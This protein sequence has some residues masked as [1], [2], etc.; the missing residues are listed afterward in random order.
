[1]KKSLKLVFAGLVLFALS[2]CG[3]GGLEDSQTSEDHTAPTVT[4]FVPANSFNNVPTDVIVSATFSEP[5]QAVNAGNLQVLTNGTAI[6]G[7]V[8][9]SNGNKVNF[10]PSANLAV[11][12]TYT[13]TVSGVKDL[14]GNSSANYSWSFTTA[15]SNSS[16]TTSPSI[17][18]FSPGSNQA[19]VLLSSPIKVTFSEAV[20]PVSVNTNHFFLNSGNAAIPCS[21]STNG[22]IATLTPSSTLTANTAYTPTVT[23]GIKDLSGNP[24]T[25]SS[26]WSFTTG[27]LS[28]GV[29]QTFLPVNGTFFSAGGVAQATFIASTGVVTVNT[30]SNAWDVSLRWPSVSYVSGGIYRASFSCSSNPQRNVEVQF[31]QNI[32]PFTVYGSANVACSGTVTTDITSSVTDNAGRMNINFG[33]ATGAYT[34]GAVSLQ[35]LN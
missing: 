8:T 30:A 35:K 5:I 18:A 23:V 34:V 29:I 25:A 14:A 9:F 3:G 10:K 15:G 2:A 20:D 26:S 22:N 33:A 16:D 6:S 28:G 24:L 32:S 13:A 1:M 19:N 4:V 7:N 12:T 11:N 31:K 17:T 21:V 27:S